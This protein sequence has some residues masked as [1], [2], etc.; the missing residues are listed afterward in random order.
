MGKIQWE[1]KSSVAETQKPTLESQGRLSRAVTFKVKPPGRQGVNKERSGIPCCSQ[2]CILLGLWTKVY[3]ISLVIVSS[4]SF[5]FV[6]TQ[7]I[8]LKEKNQVIKAVPCP[9]LWYGGLHC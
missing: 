5:I 1:F 6:S 8:W 9:V 7:E 3:R 4:Y 2:L